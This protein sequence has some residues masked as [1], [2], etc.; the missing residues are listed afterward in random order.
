MAEPTVVARY[1]IIDTRV[2][3][4][5]GTISW[6][7]DRNAFVLEV[8]YFNR[9][10]SIRQSQK[11]I[12]INNKRS[13]P[14]KGSLSQGQHDSSLREID[15]LAVFV[16]TLAFPSFRQHLSLCLIHVFYEQIRSKFI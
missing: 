11:T 15:W 5:I 3:A 16:G 12:V 13:N 2:D 10:R 7:I 1:E 9:K 4:A 8:L 6:D 14:G